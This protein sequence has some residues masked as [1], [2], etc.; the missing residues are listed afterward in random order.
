MPTARTG[1]DD[2]YE[3]GP[4]DAEDLSTFGAELDEDSE[5]T[6]VADVDVAEL[7]RDDLYEVDPAATSQ[8]RSF[9]VTRF[10]VAALRDLEPGEVLAGTPPQRLSEG[11][12]LDATCGRTGAPDDVQATRSEASAVRTLVEYAVAVG[13][14]GWNDACGYVDRERL[15]DDCVSYLQGFAPVA[16]AARDA[17]RSFDEDDVQAASTARCGYHFDHVPAFGAAT[18]VWADDGWVVESTRAR[19]V[20]RVPGRLTTA[21]RLARYDGC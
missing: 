3:A 18:V 11:D 21:R 5:D 19:K 17:L 10:S 13:H 7:E 8:D 1:R 16:G 12:F 9:G 15:P 14:A 6:F 2:G 20:F 4:A